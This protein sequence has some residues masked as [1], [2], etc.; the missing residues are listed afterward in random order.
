MRHCSS[1]FFKAKFD[2]M[3]SDENYVYKNRK[4]KKQESHVITASLIHDLIIH[5]FSMSM[6]K[7]VA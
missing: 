1:S 7:S 2:V 3:T 5:I 4:L 6:K